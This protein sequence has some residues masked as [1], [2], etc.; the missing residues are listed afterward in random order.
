MA[1]MAAGG[2]AAGEVVVVALIVVAVRRIGRVEPKPK[3]PVHD[4]EEGRDE[5]CNMG[6]L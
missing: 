6:E 3:E 5:G 4:G 1:T 2:A